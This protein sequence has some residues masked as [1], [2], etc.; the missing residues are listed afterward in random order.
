MSRA[1][2]VP[3]GVEVGVGSV[4]ARSPTRSGIGGGATDADDDEAEEEII[5]STNFQ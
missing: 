4:E 5:Y 3:G 2:G 1:D